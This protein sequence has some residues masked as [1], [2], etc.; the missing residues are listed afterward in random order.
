MN[1]LRVR[2]IEDCYPILK[3]I[4]VSKFKKT[5]EYTGC[6]FVIK[7]SGYIIKIHNES[8]TWR[9]TDGSG[10]EGN[11]VIEGDSFAIT[12]CPQ[13][14]LLRASYDSTESS[15]VHRI[16]LSDLKDKGKLELTRLNCCNGYDYDSAM[17]ESD[18]L[19]CI[20]TQ[21]VD[22]LEGKLMTVKHDGSISNH[23]D[24]DVPA[25]LGMTMEEFEDILAMDEYSE[26]ASGE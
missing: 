16:C 1:Y 2:L 14:I 13:S 18:G 17:H 11:I 10:S 5:S 23:Y 9:R 15:I 25:S 6:S 20:V 8:V 21:Y 26:Q 19:V 24:F 4:E 3:C 12:A 7:K 22:R